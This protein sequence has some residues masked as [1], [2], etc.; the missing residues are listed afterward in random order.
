MQR[1]AKRLGQARDW[2]ALVSLGKRWTEQHP[3]D[4]EGWRTLSGAYLLAGRYEEARATSWRGLLYS[5]ED[6]RLQLALCLAL[7]F[8]GEQHAAIEHCEKALKNALG[9]DQRILLEQLTAAY[10]RA[11]KIEEAARA[12]ERLLR[13]YPESAIGWRQA[14][15][16][17]SVGVLGA[18]YSSAIDRLRAIDSKMAEQT[19]R[20]LASIDRAA[21]VSPGTEQ[22]IARPPP[23]QSGYA[24]N[25][26][27]MAEIRDELYKYHTNA[28]ALARKSRN[29]S[30][31]P[32]S[33][34]LEADQFLDQGKRALQSG[35]L[36]EA[37]QAV[38]LL[39]D[40][41]LYLVSKQ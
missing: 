16:M 41:Y 20:D 9:D 18:E 33:K 7:G 1:E 28:V 30:I 6:D 10:G 31:R 25:E 26:R 34:R 35:D 5:P 21:S 19:L 27:E 22:S 15:L 12:T 23:R 11:G 8:S 14:A 29:P 17:Y 37:R 39:R 4:V 32:E 38:E 3:H 40:L 36:V 24:K 2:P 13:E